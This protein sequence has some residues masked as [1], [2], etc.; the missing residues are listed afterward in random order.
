MWETWA[1]H[2]YGWLVRVI[3]I[4]FKIPKSWTSVIAIRL[5]WLPHVSCSCCA[6]TSVTWQRFEFSWN[7]N[8]ILLLLFNRE[9]EYVKVGRLEWRNDRS[10]LICLSTC[11]TLAVTLSIGSGY[12]P[13]EY[14]S[15]KQLKWTECKSFVMPDIGTFMFYKIWLLGYFEHI[16]SPEYP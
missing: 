16:D 8:A 7:V 13:T 2:K 4:I 12:R 9:C 10:E 1:T 15:W 11:W 14:F 6:V 5:F 3:S